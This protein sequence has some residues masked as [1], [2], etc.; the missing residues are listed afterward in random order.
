MARIQGRIKTL[1]MTYLLD[2]NIKTHTANK[3][4]NAIYFTI[5][6]IIL[7]AFKTVASNIVTIIMDNPVMVK[8]RDLPPFKYSESIA[9]EII[10]PKI[11]PIIN[12]LKL[13]FFI[14]F[15]CCSILSFLPF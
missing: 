9:A 11:H 12:T 7:V 5:F 8:G 10:T 1:V 3:P 14:K 13:A 4:E 15:L 2:Q 6:I